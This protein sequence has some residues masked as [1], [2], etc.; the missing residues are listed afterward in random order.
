MAKDMK[1]SSWDI[2]DSKVLWV[3]ANTAVHSYKWAGQGTYQG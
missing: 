3:D 1:I 2:T